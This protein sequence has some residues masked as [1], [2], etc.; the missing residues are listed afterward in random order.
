MVER[1]ARDAE[2]EMRLVRRLRVAL[3]A[4]V[5][6]R[7]ELRRSGSARLG[8]LEVAKE[9]LDVG[10][11]V[12]PELP[13]DADDHALRVIPPVEVAEER[14]PRGAANRL[15]ASDDVPA[16]RLVAVQ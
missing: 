7:F 6:V 16:E 3:D 11:Q 4:R 13:R 2:A 12:V 8:R 5:T 10:R 14:V 15:L 1:I 9:P